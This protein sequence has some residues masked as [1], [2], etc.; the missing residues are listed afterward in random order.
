MAALES[1]VNA[2]AKGRERS[3]DALRPLNE[4]LT[5]YI[6]DP[7]DQAA[8]LADMLTVVQPYNMA[9]TIL[10]GK[11]QIPERQRAFDSP[12]SGS[13][14]AMYETL[15]TPHG[16]GA[17]YP[18][19]KAGEV[20]GR[21]MYDSSPK[22]Q[23]A[24]GLGKGALQAILRGGGRALDIAEDVAPK[25]VRFGGVPGA[26][27][28]LLASSPAGEGSEL[29]RPLTERDYIGGGASGHLLRAERERLMGGG[30][31]RR[32]LF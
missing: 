7:V 22:L 26:L 14:D 8:S 29:P 27:L 11:S 9:K 32:L 5:R 21:H 31:E 24:A 1:I 4:P 30:R 16:M 19:Y 10:S 20:M 17:L 13:A 18:T 23:K 25:I 28:S 12:F 6:L 3:L 15:L 2:V